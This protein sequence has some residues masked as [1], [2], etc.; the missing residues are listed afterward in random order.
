MTPTALELL[1][2]PE[3]LRK[4]IREQREYVQRYKNYVTRM[5]PTNP[6]YYDERQKEVVASAYKLLDY[7]RLR[8]YDEGLSE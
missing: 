2:D 3:F 7:F 4:R 1:N 5:R 8:L 6:L